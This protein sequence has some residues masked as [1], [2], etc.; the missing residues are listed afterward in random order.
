MVISMPLRHHLFLEHPAQLARHPRREKEARLAD[1]E[2]EAAG[3]ADGIVEHL[4]RR[5]QHRL[6]AV[7]R[8]HDAAAALKKPFHPREPGIVEHEFDAGGAGGD[9]LRQIVD[10]R[11]EAAIH[12]H[13]IGALC[14]EAKG[15][16]QR[17]PV[18]ADDRSPAHRQ[19][20]I[21]ELLAHIAEVS[22]DDLAGEDFVA[23]ANDLDAH[24]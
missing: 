1:V 17:V 16:E 15:V 13:R 20:E 2:G 23:G 4:R 6:L 7:V 21:L 3:R 10:R 12:H 8:R 5:R 11:A 24:G 22:V 14:S 19:P 9:F 18:V